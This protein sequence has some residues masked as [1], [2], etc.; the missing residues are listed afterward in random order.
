MK[1]NASKRLDSHKEFLKICRNQTP[2]S[3]EGLYVYFLR[4][5]EKLCKFFD[6]EDT[7]QFFGV[8]PEQYKNISKEDYDRFYSLNL[9]F[10]TLVLTGENIPGSLVQRIQTTKAIVGE[11]YPRFLIESLEEK[12]VS[13]GLAMFT[14]LPK[15]VAAKYGEILNSPNFNKEEF[16]TILLEVAFKDIG[17]NATKLSSKRGCYIATKIYGS[18]NSPEVILLRNFRDE[19][20]DKLIFGRMFISVYYYLSPKLIQLKIFDKT[21]SKPIRY[22]LSKITNHLNKL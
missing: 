9:A 6:R 3:L 4:G 20:L 13:K 5:S 11:K 1:S 14:E 7:S 21:L 15:I 16:S 12:G 8:K 18:Y 10:F 22:I 17:L 19:T 2:K